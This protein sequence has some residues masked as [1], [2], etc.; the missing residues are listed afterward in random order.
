MLLQNLNHC[1]TIFLFVLLQN[2]PEQ[3]H[4][5]PACCCNHCNIPMLVAAMPCLKYCNIGNWMLLPAFQWNIT[6]HNVVILPVSQCWKC[7][8]CSTRKNIQV[9][10]LHCSVW[11]AHIL[12]FCYCCCNTSLL[13]LLQY[14]YVTGGNACNAPGMSRGVG[15]A[16][17]LGCCLQFSC[18]FWNTLAI[19]GRHVHNTLRKGREEVVMFE[20]MEWAGRWGR[21]R[22]FKAQPTSCNRVSATNLRGAVSKT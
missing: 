20:L 3:L 1:N 19:H 7:K 5:C 4:H 18:K 6:M 12:V 22:S 16:F 21:R 10:F 14:H 11:L 17:G 8:S 13:L 15:P 2:P 9:C